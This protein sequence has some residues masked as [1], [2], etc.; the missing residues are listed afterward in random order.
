M[1]EILTPDALAQLRAFLVDVAAEG[2]ARAMHT[3]ISQPVVTASAVPQEPIHVSPDISVTPPASV[4]GAP[5]PAPPAEAAQPAQPATNLAA[6]PTALVP[7]DRAYF[8]RA[9]WSEVY[10]KNL[11]RPEA[12]QAVADFSL[13]FPQ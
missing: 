5:M 13:S 2:A 8:V 3:A 9:L 6:I 1:I 11:S 7:S 4:D 12:D 10:A